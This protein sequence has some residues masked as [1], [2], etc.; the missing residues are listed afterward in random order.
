MNSTFGSS[1]AT[2]HTFT[3]LSIVFLIIG[4]LCALSVPTD[5]GCDAGIPPRHWL[6]RNLEVAG[7]I[8]FAA[9][10]S[11]WGLWASF[12]GPYA[13]LPAVGFAVLACAAY[14]VLLFRREHVGAGVKVG[15][16]YL[17]VFACLIQVVPLWLLHT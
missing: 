4:V 14:S 5:K 6:S 9:L 17:T 2:Y 10:G 16:A 11:I 13:W 7:L 15:A 1:L 12:I 8:I 3:A